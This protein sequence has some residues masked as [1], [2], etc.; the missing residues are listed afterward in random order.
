MHGMLP[1][2]NSKSPRKPLAQ[3]L[4]SVSKLSVIE[5][6]AHSLSSLVILLVRLWELQNCSGVSGHHQ[7]PPLPELRV[8]QGQDQVRDG[9]SDLA[10]V[11]V[12]LK[13]THSLA[14]LSI[15]HCETG[16]PAASVNPRP[17]QWGP[18]CMDSLAVVKRPALPSETWGDG[19]AETSFSELHRWGPLGA[20]AGQAGRAGLPLRAGSSNVNK[21]QLSLP[22]ARPICL[23]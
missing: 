9:L 19:A 2:T 12:D 7:F 22:S 4:P 6:L 1:N 15:S 10:N 13:A 8:L 17:G 14:L 3:C 5:G 18:P 16:E 21:V 20:P 11:N 23:H